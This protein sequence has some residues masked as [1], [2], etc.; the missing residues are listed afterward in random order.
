MKTSRILVVAIIVGWVAAMAVVG[1]NMM[2]E[3]Q[4]TSSKSVNESSK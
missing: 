4:Q 3:D 2:N 1:Y